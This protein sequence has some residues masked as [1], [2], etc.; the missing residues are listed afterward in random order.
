MSQQKCLAQEHLNRATKLGTLSIVS[1]ELP[2]TTFIKAEG[3][4]RN[5]NLPGQSINFYI[6]TDDSI[7]ADIYTFETDE[8]M[9]SRYEIWDRKTF[10]DIL[11]K[12]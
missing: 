12:F 3:H 8:P 11:N 5:K 10:L 4:I 6:F 2:T 7:L 1:I 9:K